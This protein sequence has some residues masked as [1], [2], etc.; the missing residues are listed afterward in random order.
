MTVSDIDM[1]SMAVSLILSPVAVSSLIWRFLILS[2]DMLNM[3]AG[4][5]RATGLRA[6]FAIGIS[7]GAD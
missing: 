5:D 3:D 7:T 6:E 2:A 1:M 4:P